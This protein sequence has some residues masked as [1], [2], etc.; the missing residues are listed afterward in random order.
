MGL[1]FEM[2]QEQASDIL[3][4]LVKD[5]RNAPQRGQYSRLLGKYTTAKKDVLKEAMTNI[6]MLNELS[7][8]MFDRDV[9]T[10]K[11]EDDVSVPKMKM[12]K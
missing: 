5:F 12:N 10:F 1:S 3:L 2:L 8:S 4:K 9:I 6:K 7:N 11:D